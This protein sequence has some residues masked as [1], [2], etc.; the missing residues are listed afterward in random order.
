MLPYA[1]RPL[2]AFLALITAAVA[3]GSLVL[4]PWLD[5]EPCHLCIFQRTLFMLM[6][7]LAAL[8]AA[9]SY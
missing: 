2:W 3:L 4:T 9:L 6:A 1:P 5:L 8:T 7:L